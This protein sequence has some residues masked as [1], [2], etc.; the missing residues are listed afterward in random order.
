MKALFCLIV[1]SACSIWTA[2]WAGCPPVLAWQNSFG[3]DRLDLHF[4]IQPLRDGGYFLAGSSAS[5]ISGNKTSPFYGGVI[6]GGDGWLVRVDGQ[7][8]KLSERSFGGSDGDQFFVMEPTSDG[9]FVLGGKSRSPADGN[10]TSPNY[11]S[12]DFWLVRLDA[13]GEVLWDRSYGG[14]D[15]DYLLALKPTVDG[16]FILA[17]YSASPPGGTKTA[18]NYG[19][20]D[21]WLVR[22]DAEGN[23]LWDVS[24]GGSAS[25]DLK[26]VVVLPDGGFL[27]GGMTMSI[28]GDLSGLNHGNSDTWVLRLDPEGRL[29][30]NKTYGGTGS[31]QLRA[32]LRVPERGFLIAAHSDSVPSGNKTAPHRVTATTGLCGSTPAA[33][34]FGIGPLAD[35]ILTCYDARPRCPMGVGF[36]LVRVR[37]DPVATKPVAA[38]ETQISGWC[39]STPMGTQNGTFHWVAV[40]AT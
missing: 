1:L 18:P 17:G 23:P 21:A 34:L 13:A 22:V 10:K 30:W 19:L 26:A 11:G 3:G 25:D 35:P 24:F 29:L 5:T 7:G 40:P 14:A 4:A 32:L 20:I 31:D 38:M 2:G 28:D 8:Q 37:A 36:S 33:T 27:A 15:S 12:D 16:G 9:G 6:S 39:V